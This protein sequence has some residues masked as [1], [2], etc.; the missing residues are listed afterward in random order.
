MQQK[1][2]AAIIRAAP[3]RD[4]I[5]MP[6]IAPPERPFPDLWPP[7]APPVELGEA[8]EVPVGKTGGIDTVV[9]RWTP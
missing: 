6:A 7:D 2:T 1:I 8:D 5:T 3:M 9:G 4:P